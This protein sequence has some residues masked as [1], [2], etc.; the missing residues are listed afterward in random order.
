MGVDVHLM[1][2]D[3][4]AFARLAEVHLRWAEGRG[5]GAALELLGEAIERVRGLAPRGTTRQQAMEE[6][7]LKIDRLPVTPEDEAARERLDRTLGDLAGRALEAT[8]SGDPAAI[9]R[10]TEEVGRTVFGALFAPLLGN[11]DRGALLRELVAVHEDPPGPDLELA[12]PLEEAM[13]ELRGGG[14]PSGR[15]GDGIPWRKLFDALAVA[16]DREPRADV[17]V[18]LLLPFEGAGTL[19]D[20]VWGAGGEILRLD[21]PIAQLF[22]RDQVEAFRGELAAIPVPAPRSPER[23]ARVRRL[24]ELAAADPRLALASW[25]G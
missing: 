3:R 25:A 16:W 24:V 14:A 20:L 23:V 22:T 15:W 8:Q 4:V 2:I 1:L 12:R 9:A 11:D 18:D 5:P 13:N 21:E 7:R 6:I 17:V 19:E 10:A